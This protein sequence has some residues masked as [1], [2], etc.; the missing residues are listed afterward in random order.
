[1]IWALILIN[2]YNQETY[3]EVLAEDV[4]AFNDTMILNHKVTWLQKG[5]R[6]PG[7]E[8]CLSKSP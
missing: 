8:E 4:A 2:I 7:L 3:T 5:L 1:M 6:T